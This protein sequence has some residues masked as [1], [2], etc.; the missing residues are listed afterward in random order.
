M[1][2]T[3]T[4]RFFD[5]QLGWQRRFNRVKRSPI[6]LVT[7]HSCTLT[8]GLVVLGLAPMTIE[9]FSKAVIDVIE[10]I[11]GLVMPPMLFLQLVLPSNVKKVSQTV[12]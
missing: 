8:P 1:I 4:E 9:T 6:K 12:A 3:D 5:T 7:E 2:N 11:S 10:V